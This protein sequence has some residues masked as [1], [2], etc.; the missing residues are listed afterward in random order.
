M[1][2]NILNRIGFTVDGDTGIW[3]LEVK[4]KGII[5]V[6]DEDITHATIYQ[7]NEYQEDVAGLTHILSKINAALI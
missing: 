5:I 7:D 6:T 1:Y 3:E 2:S 4:E